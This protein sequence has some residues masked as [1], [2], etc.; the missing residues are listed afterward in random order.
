MEGFIS[1]TFLI[2]F[3]KVN[4]GSKLEHFQAKTKPLR[5]PP[6]SEIRAWLSSRFARDFGPREAKSL[7]RSDNLF[8][9]VNFK[10]MISPMSA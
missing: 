5:N 6:R 9:L 8:I 4:P 2:L 3:L 1:I 7:R 10:W